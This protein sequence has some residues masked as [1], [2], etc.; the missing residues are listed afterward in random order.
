[1]RRR[2]RLQ[3]KDNGAAIAGCSAVAVSGTGNVRSANLRYRRA[4]RR[5]SCPRGDLLG[6]RRQHSSTS[7]T[8][9]QT[10]NASATAGSVNVAL[11]SNGGIASASSSYSAAYPVS[12]VNDNVRSGAGWGAGGGWNDGTPGSFPDWVQI[13]FN[14]QKTIDHV[15][16]YTVAG[17]LHE[18][19]RAHRY[20]DV[21][22]VRRHRVPGAGMER[23]RRG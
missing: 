22:D 1:M 13:N 12:A 11:A 3:F 5:Q 8:L 6:R 7:A 21:L 4:C 16:V 23:H 10:V 15:V 19:G 20:D 18:S 9:T 14:G 17:Q 2:D